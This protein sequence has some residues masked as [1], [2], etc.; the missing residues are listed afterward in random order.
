MV[1]CLQIVAYFPM[2]NVLMPANCVLLFTVIVKI[3]TFD[4]IPVDI[5][6]DEIDEILKPSPDA[7]VM[8]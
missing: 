2:I 6:M 5:I 3:V 8:Q 1:N 7:Y 4:M